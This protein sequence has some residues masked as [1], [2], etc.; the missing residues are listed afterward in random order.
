MGSHLA[1]QFTASLD[2]PVESVSWDDI[3]IFITRLNAREYGV[4]TYRLPTEAEWEYA[5]HAGATAA[6]SE[7]L[8]KLHNIAWCGP[9]ARNQPH[10]VGQLDAN[11]WG[12]RDMQGNV[13]EWVQDWYRTPYP[14]TPG[15]S[16][17]DPQGPTHGTDRVVR[18]GSWYDPAW[19]CRVTARQ[20]APPSE[21]HRKRGFRLLRMPSRP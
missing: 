15:Q 18:G 16:V 17:T 20:H 19:E 14:V 2:L 10:P 12:L 7:E 3:Q 9:N 13:A 5:A 6:T 8:L 4:A 11:A 1:Q 21:R